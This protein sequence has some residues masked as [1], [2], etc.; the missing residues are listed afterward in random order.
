MLDFDE[1]CNTLVEGGLSINPAELQGGLYGRL[2]G[3]KALSDQDLQIFAEQLIGV[4][5]AKLPQVEEMFDTLHRHA[6]LQLQE[7]HELVK[8]LLPD[9]DEPISTRIESLSV[10]C[11]SFLSGL[12]QSGLSGET[13]LAA[14]VAEAM[15]DLAAIALVDPESQEEDG[16][17]SYAELVEFVRVA[18]SLIHVELKHLMSTPVEHRH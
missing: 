5:L 16:E 6:L 14:D 3:G 13:A 18:S 7:Q 15:R 17:A 4:S 10:W 9:D 8:L 1:C 2:C 11:Q 12:G